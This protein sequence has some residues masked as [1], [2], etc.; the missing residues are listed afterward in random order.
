MTLA[1]VLFI[2]LAAAFLSNQVATYHRAHSAQGIQAR[3]SANEGIA[4]ITQELSVSSHTWAAAINGVFN[5]PYFE[6]TGTSPPF[7]VQCFSDC[8]TG[9]N[10]VFPD[11]ETFQIWCSTGVVGNP[12]LQP[13]QVA[14]RVVAS[15]ASA[16][17]GAS[18]SKRAVKAY[19]S[20]RTIGVDT[21]SGVHAG[22][23]LALA[24]GYVLGFGTAPNATVHWG[25]I[26]SLAQTPLIV[27]GDSYTNH[28]PRKFAT[29]MITGGLG[30]SGLSNS[31]LDSDQKEYWSNGDVT[32]PVFSYID[33]SSYIE[34]ARGW[35][36][37]LP[38]GTGLNHYTNDC[39]GANPSCGYFD[40]EDNGGATEVFDAPLP[41]YSFPPGPPRTIYVKGNAEFKRLNVDGATIIITGNLTVSD[42]SGGQPMTLN[43]PVTAHSEYPFFPNW[44]CQLQ[45]GATCSSGAV[46]PAPGNVQFRGFLWVQGSM[47]LTFPNTSAPWNMA[48]VLMVGTNPPGTSAQTLSPGVLITGNS[49]MYLAYDDAINHSILVQPVS[50]QPIS[51][52]AIKVEPDLI[53]DDVS[54]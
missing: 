47:T 33:E 40:P 15:G 26:L 20:K 13:Y 45:E 9:N 27:S 7:L 17:G 3:A 16:A 41:G 5:G 36:N 35:T 53:Q 18:N 1:L 10:V 54:N 50:G 29:G 43:V 28:Y 31:G 52:T 12:G 51:G 48:G 8:N 37:N 25:P 23:A 30:T 21:A 49:A 22:A 46:F 42:S 14:V 6:Q 44:P 19:L 34:Q 2:A 39:P 38:G 32:I 24:Q 4:L 11:G